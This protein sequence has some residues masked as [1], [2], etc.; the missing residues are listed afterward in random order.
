MD[1]VFAR[2]GKRASRGGSF[3][4][5]QNQTPGKPRGTFPDDHPSY[6][7]PVRYRVNHSLKERMRW[8][9]HTDLFFQGKGNNHD[10]LDHQI[11]VTPSGRGIV[12]LSALA[13]AACRGGDSTNSTNNTG[14]QC[15]ASGLAN[16]LNPPLGRAACEQLLEGT[17]GSG[18]STGI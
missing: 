1:I 10:R 5:P 8:V 7:Y 16:L 12:G 13:L 9:Q 11:E 3:G 2:R 15:T 4:I 18:S 17:G 6:W 14:G